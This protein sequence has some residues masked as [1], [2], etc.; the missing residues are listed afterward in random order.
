M[1]GVSAEFDDENLLTNVALT[2]TV[3][4]N[5]TDGQTTEETEETT[6]EISAEGITAESAT[7][8]YLPVDKEGGID[9]SSAGVRA[10]YESLG[11]IC[12]V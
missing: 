7:E 4:Y 11:F 1:I 6:T 3:T 8:V 10:N 2:E 5:A 9:L 12:E